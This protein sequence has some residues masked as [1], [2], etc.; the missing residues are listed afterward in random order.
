MLPKVC[1]FPENRF[2]V[3]ILTIW[4][5]ST[6]ILSLTFSGSI[7]AINS[8][9]YGY[10][11]PF[12][13]LHGMH[14]SGYRF[15]IRKGVWQDTINDVVE[16]VADEE[17]KYLLQQAQASVYLKRSELDSTENY[18]R[19][20]E[21]QN[22]VFLGGVDYQ[23]LWRGCDYYTLSIPIHMT[24]TTTLDWPES[25]VSGMNTFAISPE[26]KK[27]KRLFEQAAQRLVETGNNI[28]VVKRFQPVSFTRNMI[29][30][31]ICSKLDQTRI[32][33][34]PYDSVSSS[35]EENFSIFFIWTLGC[36]L[37]LVVFFV[38]AAFG[39]CGNRG[40]IREKDLRM[41]LCGI[42]QHQVQEY[43]STQPLEKLELFAETFYKLKHS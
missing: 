24:S 39:G 30:H 19:K 9:Y 25:F 23:F 40:R 41:A 14:A 16:S 21:L 35:L 36:G 43:L 1:T 10:S 7:M 33:A 2:I 28:A 22:I 17:E 3:I 15:G 20:K 5:F 32:A 26:L 42:L 34:L 6:V 31:R 37:C 13:D 27:H 18:L 38:E 11:A 29:K 4:S 8:L 12:Y